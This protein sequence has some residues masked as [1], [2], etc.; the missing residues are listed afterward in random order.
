MDDTRAPSNPGLFLFS[1]ITSITMMIAG[2]ATRPAVPPTRHSADPCDTCIAGVQNFAKVS[3]SLWRGSQ[4]TQE[5]F[6]SLEAAGVKTILSLRERHD[7][8]PLLK[9]TNL[10][11]IRIP[12]DAWDPEEAELV[13]LLTLLERVLNDP[14]LRPV[15]IHCAEGKDRTGYGIAAY[16]M[17][18][19]NWTPDDA[20]HEMFDFRFN[21]IWFRNPTFLRNLN[22]E[23]VRSAMKLAP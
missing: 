22:I 5:G 7:D 15:F 8:L 10:K 21:P 2:C 19:E 1:A 17:V 3:P 11:Y 16:R 14:E 6:R 12:M 23:K 20:I 9:E 13:L 4:P 18:F